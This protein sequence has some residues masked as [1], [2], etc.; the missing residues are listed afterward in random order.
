M[1]CDNIIYLLLNILIKITL[2]NISIQKNS[3]L[4]SYEEH[5]SKKQPLEYATHLCLLNTLPCQPVHCPA[6]TVTSQVR[7]VTFYED[8]GTFT[9]TSL[10]S[11]GSNAQALVIY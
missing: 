1:S 6:P 5:S 11:G 4:H 2:D 10:P 3:Y 7:Q 8:L 9:R